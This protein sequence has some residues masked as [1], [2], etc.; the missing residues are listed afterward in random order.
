MLGSVP[1]PPLP[2]PEAGSGRFGV[3]PEVEA[4]FLAPRRAPVVEAI[5]RHRA[6]LALLVRRAETLAQ[7]RRYEDAA[8]AAQ[9][10]ANHAVLWHAGVFTDPALEAVLW[11]I[12]RGALPAPAPQS[13]HPGGKR[14][15]VHLATSVAPIGGHSRMIWRWIRSDTDSRHSVILTRQ[16]EQ[17]P[18][19]CVMRFRHRAE[20]WRW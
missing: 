5:A 14:K 18:Q 11:R 17:P 6:D 19:P 15:I 1:L 20:Y 16:Y 13:P 7:G 8:V 9:I 3:D 2:P 4:G 12:G 10:A